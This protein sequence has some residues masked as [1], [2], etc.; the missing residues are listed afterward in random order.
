ML[1]HRAMASE[2]GMTEPSGGAS[3]AGRFVGVVFNAVSAPF[4]STVFFGIRVFS[5]VLIMPPDLQ[6]LRGTTRPRCH[7]CRARAPSKH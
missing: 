5:L 2:A 4:G 6:A 7:V 1:K 3:G